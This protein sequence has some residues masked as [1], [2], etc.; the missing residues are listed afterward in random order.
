M[1]TT[2]CK[3][4]NNPC[5]R[6]I[7]AALIDVAIILLFDIVL[8]LP[9]GAALVNNLVSRT[10]S[11]SIALFF[12]SLFSGAFLLGVDLIY[13]VGLPL[14]KN[15]Q[16]VGLRF[17]DLKIVS[18]DGDNPKTKQYLV[19]FLSILLLAASTLG[20]A[21]IAEMVSIIASKKHHSCVDELSRTC[22]IDLKEKENK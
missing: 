11:S 2:N 7:L 16:T 3:N 5:S 14:Y 18:F 15:G 20:F 22:I 6:R 10:G 17:F 8:S 21:L 4:R 9:A 12:S 19:R 1:E 13:L